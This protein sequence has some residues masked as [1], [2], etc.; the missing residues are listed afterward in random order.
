MPILCSSTI[1]RV[2]IY[3]RGAVVTR[4][5]HLPPTLPDGLVELEVPEVTS[6]AEPGSLRLMLDGARIPLSIRAQAAS[7]TS[8]RSQSLPEKARELRHRIDRLK[9]EIRILQERR[10]RLT[11]LTPDA[12]PGAVTGIDARVKLA[13]GTGKLL[14]ELIGRLD[15]RWFELEEELRRASEQLTTMELTLRQLSRSTKVEEENTR[16]L[17]I[18][19]GGSGKLVRAEVSYLIAPA[20][21]WPLYTLRVVEGRSA[22]L[23]VE[24]LVA[25]LSGEDWSAAQLSFATSDLIHDARMPELA[26]L[27]L[28]RTQQPVRSGYRPPPPGLAQLF[29][30]FD[31]YLPEMVPPKPISEEDP[32]V[33]YTLRDILLGGALTQGGAHKKEPISRKIST[34]IEELQEEDLLER[35]EYVPAPPALLA[36]QELSEPKKKSSRRPTVPQAPPSGAALGGRGG[37]GTKSKIPPP[38]T[39]EPDET[40]LDLSRLQLGSVEDQHRRGQLYLAIDDAR[41]LEAMRRIEALQPPV[42]TVCDPRQSRGQFAYRYDAGARG[43]V[44]SDGVPHLV[45]VLMAQAPMRVS[46]RTIPRENP[47]VYREAQFTNPFNA[48]LLAGPV[49]VYVDHSL[50]ATTELER[51]ARGGV[52]KVGLG[53]EPRIRV[54][55]NV[56]T[57]EGSSGLLGGSTVIQ[58]TIRVD[59]VSSLGQPIEIEIVER[60]PVSDDKQIL[61][62]RLTTSPDAQTYDQS[63][64]GEPIRGGLRWLLTLAP[65]GNTRVEHSF[66]ITIPA[67]YELSGGNRRE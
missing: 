11:Q 18:Q 59:V 48:P 1:D 45:P 60:V 19:L 6:L 47:E 36:K 9:D 44:P 12:L 13:I 38:P 29:G 40:F 20:R 30:A 24:A 67:K 39:L 25:Q 8:Q 31:R 62:E 50:L 49:Q 46:F 4:T 14:D 35:D 5:L 52:V 53:V 7:E 34:E 65:A 55:R 37:G 42:N 15:S 33:N 2:T 17:R 21:W 22:S 58:E 10:E 61:V 28:G 57:Q 43:T 63:E 26:S 51:V 54:A 56:Q 23:S 41:S 3:A 27:R 66:R 16:S 64:R 32:E